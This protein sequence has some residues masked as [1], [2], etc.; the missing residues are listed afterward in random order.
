[1]ASSSS[2]ASNAF[3][4]ALPAVSVPAPIHMPA[5]V[6]P[7]G[8]AFEPIALP[9]WDAGA[10][11]LARQIEIIREDSEKI[12]ES[13]GIIRADAEKKVA[14]L[15]QLGAELSFARLNNMVVSVIVIESE[16]DRLM[17]QLAEMESKYYGLQMV[18]YERKEL[19]CPCCNARV[20]KTN[21]R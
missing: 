8:M 21:S 9:K 14:H 15:N 20:M 13:M 1:M 19:C 7:A 10:P 11:A 6:H 4:S 17:R 12:A 16:I 2:S 3:F 18:G 5:P